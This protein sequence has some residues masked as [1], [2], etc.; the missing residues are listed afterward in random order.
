LDALYYTLSLHDALPLTT[1]I[2]NVGTDK[3]SLVAFSA[4]TYRARV[5]PVNDIIEGQ[6]NASRG[7]AEFS[8]KLRVVGHTLLARLYEFLEFLNTVLAPNTGAGFTS[9]FHS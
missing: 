5:I 3:E 9:Y 7:V 8:L 2:G 1:S 4:D 6:T